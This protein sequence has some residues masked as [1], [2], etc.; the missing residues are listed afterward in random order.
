M[1]WSEEQRKELLY[2]AK[3][4]PQGY[5]RMKALAVWN[6]ASGHAKAE[7]ARLIG[8]SR[9]SVTVWVKSYWQKGGEA[10]LVKKGRG[11]KEKAKREEVENY[12]RQSPG[13][14]GFEQS[15]WTL[16]T[17]ARSVPSLKNFTESGVYR[18]LVRMGYR[19]KRG[20]PHLHS[21]DPQYSEKRG[22]WN[23]PSV[24]QELIQERL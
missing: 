3:H 19:Y 23:R 15:R 12:L 9:V 24:K 10:F 20:Q 21:P 14:F 8:V 18:L 6:V 13:Q 2:I 11:R 5:V 16:R 22:L 1:N 17:L 4:A 7:V